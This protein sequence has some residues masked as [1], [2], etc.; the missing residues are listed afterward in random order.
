[1]V[2]GLWGSMLPTPL[3]STMCLNK[4]QLLFAWMLSISGNYA[5]DAQHS[6]GIEQDLSAVR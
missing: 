3:N 5:D 2:S 1:M 6:V 4:K